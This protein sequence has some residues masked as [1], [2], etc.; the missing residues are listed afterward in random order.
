MCESPFVAITK[1]LLLMKFS[2]TL[3]ALCISGLV[4]SSL[5]AFAYSGES[6]AKD[7]KISLAQAQTIALSAQPGTIVDTELEHEKGGSSLRYS[8]DVKTSANIVHEVGID[9]QSGAVLENSIDS[10]ND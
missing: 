6:L 9:A 5:P 10:G 2:S 4:A 1:G 8:F 7:A 3:A